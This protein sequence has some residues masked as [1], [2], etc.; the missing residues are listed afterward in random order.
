MNN[1]FNEIKK[2]FITNK[3]KFLLNYNK[4][5]SNLIQKL[6]IKCNYNYNSKILFLKNSLIKLILNEFKIIHK[7]KGNCLF[8]FTHNIYYYNR[9]F[10]KH[11]NI[12]EPKILILGKKTANQDFLE[13]LYKFS[14]KEDFFTKLFL[15]IKTNFSYLLITL[16]ELY[17]KSK[18]SF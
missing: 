8:F 14:R 1:T 13:N 7:P 17:E 18:K 10:L 3:Y 9:L 6:R 16:K 2:L 11:K 5:K 15:L 12:F 4:L